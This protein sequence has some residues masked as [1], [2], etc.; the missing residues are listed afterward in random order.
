MVIESSLKTNVNLVQLKMSDHGR[1]VDEF[2]VR[3]KPGTSGTRKSV[4][5]ISVF[6]GDAAVCLPAAPG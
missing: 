6:A 3:L 2:D 1:T 4:L 5:P